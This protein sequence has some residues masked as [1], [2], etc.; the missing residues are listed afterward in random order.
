MSA[1]LSAFVTKPD[2][3]TAQRARGRKASIIQLTGNSTWLRQ[4]VAWDAT[5]RVSSLKQRQA[6]K[7]GLIDSADIVTGFRVNNAMARSWT[8]IGSKGSDL[9][10]FQANAG[11]ITKR[12]QSV[13]NFGNDTARDRFFFTNNTKTHGPFNH[14]QRYVIRNFGREDVVTLRNIGRSFGYNDLVSYGN[15]VMGFRG[16]D[17]T[18]LRVVPISGL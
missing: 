13:I 8:F 15:G 9:I 18:K 14:M 10:D 3:I 6:A 1:P 16:V 4:P 5:M 11:A 7:A 12:S 17:P 2:W